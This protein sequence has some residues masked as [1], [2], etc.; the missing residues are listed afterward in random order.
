MLTKKENKSSVQ[1]TEVNC[2]VEKIKME[3]VK[4]NES[5]DAETIAILESDTLEL[6]ENN[7]SG[8]EFNESQST[9]PVRQTVREII[10]I[11]IGEE[12]N[13]SLNAVPVRQTAREIIEITDN[14]SV[15]S[16]LTPEITEENITELKYAHESR[17]EAR[18]RLEAN[19]SAWANRS[20]AQRQAQKLIDQA[21]D[22][23]EH[24]NRAELEIEREGKE[25]IAKNPGFVVLDPNV[26][27]EYLKR[28][29]KRSKNDIKA[30]IVDAFSE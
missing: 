10:E 23:E 25:K 19:D 22:L 13:E 11:E 3:N 7:P 17:E 21:K 26:V 30:D 14:E 24:L 15:D 8:E 18:E 2:A 20:A 9:V 27:E 16:D 4:F 12:L 6:S 29:K 1:E 28:D 5:L